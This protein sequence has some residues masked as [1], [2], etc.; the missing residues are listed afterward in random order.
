MTTSFIHSPCRR[1]LHK[2]T[3]PYDGTASAAVLRLS[4][5]TVPRKRKL[6]LW[7]YRFA[8]TIISLTSHI[9]DIASQTSLLGHPSHTTLSLRKRTSSLNHSP[10]GYVHVGYDFD[11]ISDNCLS[12]AS[13]HQRQQCRISMELL[14]ST[15]TTIVWMQRLHSA[16]ICNVYVEHQSSERLPLKP[17]SAL[18]LFTRND[19]ILHEGFP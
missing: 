12:T 14:C 9:R 11:V 7:R 17:P 10:S 5:K 1:D 15:S 4:T 2:N 3:I 19:G 13:T 16:L 6:Y 8:H 18:C